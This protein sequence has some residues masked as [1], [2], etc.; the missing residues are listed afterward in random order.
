MTQFSIDV[1]VN[2]RPV[3]RGMDRVDRRLKKTSRES[4]KLITATESKRA[5]RAIQA[6]V[7][8]T[9]GKIAGAFD[10]KFLRGLLGFTGLGI[11]VR[12]V[13]QLG[14]AFTDAQNRL[15]LLVD[16]EEQLARKTQRLFDIARETRSSFEG[17]AEL[18]QRVGL[19]AKSLG[20]NS[21]DLERVV[22]NVNRA[23]IL[24]GASAKEANNGLIQLAQGIA[25]N[26]L[27][28]DEL[29]SVLEQL[30][31]VADI[32]AKSMTE[33][34][35]ALGL[36]GE[37]AEVTR[38]EL[39]DLGAAGKI[40]G[41]V[42]LKAFDDLAT[43]EELTA[44]FAKTVPTLSQSFVVLKNSTIEVFAAINSGV[45][46]LTGLAKG[47]L[48]L[49]DSLM[50]LAIASVAAAP[51]AAIAAW[52]TY[53]LS[54]KSARN[55]QATAAAVAYQLARA[56]QAEATVAIELAAAKVAQ[57]QAT[58]SQVRAG[59][60]YLGTVVSETVAT[61]ALAAANLQLEAA[62]TAQLAATGRMAAASARATRPIGVMAT[63]FS[64]L[65]GALVGMVNAVLSPVGFVAAL[66]GAGV[67]LRSFRS[68]L[69]ASDTALGRFAIL[70]NAGIDNIKEGL[71]SLADSR[72]GQAV[73]SF[74][75]TIADVVQ[76]AFSASLFDEFVE[77]A[78]AAQTA[79]DQLFKSDEEIKEEERI[80]RLTASTLGLG[81]SIRTVTDLKI[82]QYHAG[83]KLARA[84]AEVANATR[85]QEEAAAALA[86]SLD[87]ILTKQSDQLD[88]LSDQIAG[89]KAY[90]D[91]LKAQREAERKASEDGATLDASTRARIGSNQELIAAMTVVNSVLSGSRTETQKLAE[92]MDLVAIAFEAGEIS[93]AQLDVVMS[94]LTRKMEE[95]NAKAAKSADVFGN[96]RRE[97]VDQINDLQNATRTS[98]AYAEAQVA[99]REANRELSEKGMPLL[100]AEQKEQ[101]RTLTEVNK[102]L[103]VYS[104]QVSDSMTEAEKYAENLRLV[105]AALTA[106]L[107]TQEEYANYVRD[108]T[109]AL[110]ELNE[111]AD[112]FGTLRLGLVDQINDLQ[113]ATR[114]SEAYAEAQALIREANR[115]LADEGLPALNVEQKEQ[116]RTLVQAVQG[117]EAYKSAVED[118]STPLQQYQ[119]Q[120]EAV[121]AA[122]AAGALSL[123]E[124]QEYIR[125]TSQQFRALNDIEFTFDERLL[126]GVRSAM[127]SIEEINISALNA[128]ADAG[129]RASVTAINSLAEMAAGGEATFK[130]LMAS[131]LTIFRDVINQM[132][133]DLIRLQIQQA[134]VGF[135]TGPG[136]GVLL[137]GGSALP[138]VTADNFGSA[139]DFGPLAGARA[140]GGT[141]HSM[142]RPYLVGEEGPELFFPGRTGTVMPNQETM[143]ALMGTNSQ[144]GPTEAPSVNVAAPQVN[145]TNVLDAQ[146]V[147]RKGLTDSMIIEAISRNQAQVRQELN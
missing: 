128:V 88:F 144:A 90:A 59:N 83:V 126:E 35:K 36:T 21:A 93:V 95:A 25:A 84:Q 81:D 121:Q 98:E 91:I 39:R 29:R 133:A 15:R 32:I 30:P 17:T 116:I 11:V 112:V 102:G 8:R 96:L 12:E 34:N 10:T 37:A 4:E 38:G 64:K 27:S 125:L 26:R 48:L 42:V 33:T 79:L 99:I 104:E 111:T 18:Y 142:S 68:Q 105:E 114:T 76:A 63:V 6:E 101:I 115:E 52:Q 146:D 77:S 66:L 141:T 139:I 137:P 44:Q 145:V 24:S 92:Q 73:I 110:E 131:I 14:D 72:A 2:T 127:S 20:Q 53:S 46:I 118:A 47:V 54:I 74:F 19:A 107:L 94:A 80:A 57:A 129:A 9:A 143:K 136:S 49:A 86:E 117:L 16:G 135:F 75:T 132:I 120:L 106:G 55:E 71:Q 113:N 119:S 65:K 87:T 103:E 58:L 124:Y 134:I 97:I 108:T 61:E 5:L 51:L 140:H 45:P 50:A 109:K 43:T 70:F 62:Q 13:L 89:G 100:N 82:A 1:T 138:G 3:E 7:D 67:A 56:E 130:D 40:S 41:E 60:A 147:V 22:T 78:L 28:G 122:Y 23:I 69:S 31:K 123:A 85:T